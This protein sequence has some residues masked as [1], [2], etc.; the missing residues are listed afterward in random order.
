MGRTRIPQ[1]AATDSSAIRVDSHASGCQ[2]PL[3][4]RVDLNSLPVPG[5]GLLRPVGP[6]AGAP[7]P[8][9]VD[10]TGPGSQRGA[11]AWSNT[12]SRPRPR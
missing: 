3:P 1:S 8:A 10:E 11:M 5:P 7:I 6:E 12:A 9:P 4:P 2:K